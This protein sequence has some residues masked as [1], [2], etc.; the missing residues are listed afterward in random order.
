MFLHGPRI[1]APHPRAQLAFQRTPAG[2]LRCEL[3][4]RVPPDDMTWRGKHVLEIAARDASAGA[5]ADVITD[6]CAP[7][8]WHVGLFIAATRLHGSGESAELYLSL[9][10]WMREGGA[11]WARLGVVIGNT[12][13]ERFW[14][15]RG[16]VEVQ[17]RKDVPMKDRVVDLRV[18]AKPLAGGTIAEYR[19]IMPRDDP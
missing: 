17:R 14:N 10:S 13:A 15:K 11:A 18:M 19:S 4:E 1:L 5:I 12:A 2:V 6:L 16:Y 9:E 3:F 8:V 7:G